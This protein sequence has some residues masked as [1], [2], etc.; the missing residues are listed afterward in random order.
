MS[1]DYFT[2]VLQHGAQVG[3]TQASTAGRNLLH[4]IQVFVVPHLGDVGIQMD[5]I[6]EKQRAGIYS[7]VTARALINLQLQ[8]IQTLLEQMVSLAAQEIQIIINTIV[9]ALNNA[10][11]GALGFALLA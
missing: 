6:V 4:D 10:V 7:D 11:N 2:N 5:S 9:A 3:A 8:T 1:A